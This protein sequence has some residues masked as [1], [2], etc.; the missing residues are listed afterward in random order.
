VA[1]AAP[2]LVSYEGLRLLQGRRRVGRAELDCLVSFE[3]DGIDGEDAVGAGEFGPLHRVDSDASDADD[4]HVLTRA[5]LGA[6]HRRTPTC[7]D[8][9]G[10]QTG[11]VQR[12]VR[13]DL[14]AAVLVDHRP[15]GERSEQAH[16]EIGRASCRERV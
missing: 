15:F 2:G 5:H 12:Y 10:Q 4:S 16:E 1:H 14:D 3:R 7:Q 8:A 9:A 13:V 6:V 11:L